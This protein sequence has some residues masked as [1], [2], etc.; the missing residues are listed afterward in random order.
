MMCPCGRP[1]RLSHR[2]PLC[3]VCAYRVR[4]ANAE[5][6]KIEREFKREQLRQWRERRAA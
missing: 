4:V 6:S 1:L 5:A 2:S 3:A